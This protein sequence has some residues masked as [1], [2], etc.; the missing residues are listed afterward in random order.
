MYLSTIPENAE[1]IETL[2][3]TLVDTKGVLSAIVNE[4]FLVDANVLSINQDV[5]QNGIAEVSL[6][7]R[8]AGNVGVLLKNLLKKLKAVNGV[9]RLT[10]NLG[11][12]T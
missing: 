12:L 9:K 8:I 1:E 6:T 2:S 3:L 10:D 5:P 11:G 7:M 4:I